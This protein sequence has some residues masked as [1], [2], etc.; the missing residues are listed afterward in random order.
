MGSS[1]NYLCIG[2]GLP[3]YPDFVMCRIYQLGNHAYAYY[4]GIPEFHLGSKLLFGL[5]RNG[6][7]YCAYLMALIAKNSTYCRKTQWHAVSC[8]LLEFSKL[9]FL[10]VARID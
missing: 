6:S 9:P 10:V 4:F 3:A 7:V 1:D 5:I 2:A 8:Q